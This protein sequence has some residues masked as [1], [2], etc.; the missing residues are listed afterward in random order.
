[1]WL[2][3]KILIVFWS[4]KLSNDEVLWHVDEEKSIIS[5]I[6]K[7]QKAWLGHTLCHGDLLPLVIEGRVKGRTRRLP[8]RLR[9][10]ILDRIKNGSLCQ[11]VKRRA[12]ERT[13]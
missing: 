12:I 13:L 2:W 8:G 11:S 1:M 4:D 6:K 5:T 9:T 10:G 7:R 3:R